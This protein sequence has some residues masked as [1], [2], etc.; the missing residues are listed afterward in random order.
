M[1]PMIP[2][3][4]EQHANRKQERRT[5]RGRKSRPQADLE[6]RMDSTVT[7][8]P[9]TRR[10]LQHRRRA[11]T[12]DLLFRN[13]VITVTAGFYADGTLGEVFISIGKSG[14]D[15]A[16]VARDAGV[17]ISLALQHHV[18]IDT[19]RHAVTRDARGEAASL[20]GAVVDA[21]IV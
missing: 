14:T 8:S 5:K 6:S 19:L 21:L 17:V 4:C 11:E 10:R 1:Q 3:A 13:H 12:F 9:A 16:S 18:E 7:L 2:A 20:I 15:I